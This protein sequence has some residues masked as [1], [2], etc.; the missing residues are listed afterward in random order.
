MSVKVHKANNEIPEVKFICIISTKNK[1]IILGNS[2]IAWDIYL[3]N[4]L[5]TEQCLAFATLNVVSFSFTI[6]CL[7]S[8]SQTSFIIL[9]RCFRDSYKCSSTTCP[10]IICLPVSS[11]QS[12]LVSRWNRSRLAAVYCRTFFLV[13]LVPWQMKRDFF[14]L[15]QFCM[16]LT[17]RR[18]ALLYLQTPT[19]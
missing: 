6:H 8:L 18:T 16:N 3:F 19:A 7:C 13:L 11:H 9:K 5:R 12:N 17:I 10:S 1:R 15:S 14:F 2:L 4:P